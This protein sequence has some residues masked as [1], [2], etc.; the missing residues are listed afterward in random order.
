MHVM[1]MDPVAARLALRA[2]KTIASADGEVEEHELGLIRA[3]ARTMQ[4]EVDASELVPIVTDEL[5]SAGLGPR[6]AERVVQASIL[7]ALMDGRV[8]ATEVDRVRGM[9]AA[10]GVEDARVEN[11]AQL[12][13]GRMRL[14]WLDLARRSFAREVFVK[15]FERSGPRGLW[16]IVGPMIGRARDPELRDRYLDL[17]ELPPDTLGRAYFEFIVANELGFPGEPYAVPE[18]GTWHDI[19]HVLG[20]Y[21]TSPKEEVQVVSF[22]AGFSR[23]D[24][25]FWLFTIALQFHLGVRM[26]PYSKPEKG[27]FDPDLVM[28]AFER[29]AAMN[30]DLS[31]PDFDAWPYFPRPL[32][33]V[34]RELGVPDAA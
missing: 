34:R 24:P 26:S 3:V 9:A 27:H 12:A 10:L 21:G 22:I 11:L 29:G 30:T 32:E 5:A 18:S 6:D 17:A 7:T 2:M 28:R 19:A 20:G 1:D 16:N 4:I 31:A 13:R 25:F 15:A 33:E 23:E 14:L 8:D